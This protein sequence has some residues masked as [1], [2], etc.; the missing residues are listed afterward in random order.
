VD[1][2]GDSLSESDD[3]ANKTS[4]NTQLKRKAPNQIPKLMDNKRKHLEKT[5]SAAQRDKM[6]LDEAKEDTKF[7]KDLSQSINRSTDSFTNAMD[8]VSSTLMQLGKSICQS[9]EMLSR[10][11]I[12]Q[13][14]QQHQPGG[15]NHNIFYQN[16]NLYSSMG[17]PHDAL[18]PNN[19]TEIGMQQNMANLAPSMQSHHQGPSFNEKQM[20]Y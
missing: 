1:V 18:L 5:L 19:E 15:V 16:R 6:L 11:M 9:V 12:P 7:R 3:D 17:I 13:Q 4:N 2:D 20:F 8:G 10:A 14:Q